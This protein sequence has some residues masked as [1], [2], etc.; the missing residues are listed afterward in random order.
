MVFFAPCIVQVPSLHM[1]QDDEEEAASFI[2]QEA[3]LQLERARVE[4]AARRRQK[5][6]IDEVFGIGR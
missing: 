1:E 2:L 4:A 6:F 5:V 3:Q